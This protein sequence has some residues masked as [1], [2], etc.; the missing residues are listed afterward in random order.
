MLFAVIYNARGN[1]SEESEK[2][3]LR[4]FANWTPPAGFDIRSHYTFADGTGGLVLA[5]AQSAEAVLESI[6]L[7]G[8]FF[9]YRAV[10]VV[11][12]EASMPIFQKTTAWRDTVS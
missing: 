10:P 3:S 8:P 11:N 1:S 12:V 7:W 5:D 2:R 6:A 4:L 9:T